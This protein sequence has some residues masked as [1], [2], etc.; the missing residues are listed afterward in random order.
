MENTLKT[1]IVIDDQK[2]VHLITSAFLSKL[3]FIIKNF[4]SA[5]EAFRFLENNEVDLL[6]TDLNMPQMN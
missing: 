6:I 5:E 3:G 1:I 4:Y 2:A